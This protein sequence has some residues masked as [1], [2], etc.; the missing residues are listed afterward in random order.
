MFTLEKSFN[1]NKYFRQN[2][3][4]K[5]RAVSKQEIG[6]CQSAIYRAAARQLRNRDPHSNNTALSQRTA[7]LAAA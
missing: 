5:K 2:E 6:G 3:G 7:A 4:P 1:K